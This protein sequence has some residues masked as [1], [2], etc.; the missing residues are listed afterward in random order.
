VTHNG[1]LVGMLSKDG[2][3]RFVEIRKVLDES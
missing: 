1:A 3:A 2:L